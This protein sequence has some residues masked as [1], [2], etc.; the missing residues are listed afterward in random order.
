M[1]INVLV[2]AQVAIT[3]YVGVERCSTS[4]ASFSKEVLILAYARVGKISEVVGSICYIIIVSSIVNEEAVR[5]G[6]ESLLG[7]SLFSIIFAEHISVGETAIRVI[8]IKEEIGNASL[9]VRSFSEVQSFVSLYLNVSVGFF[10]GVSLV[11][12]ISKAGQGISDITVGSVVLFFVPYM[13][14]I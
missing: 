3:P 13:G 9:P 7:R 12:G 6:S 2:I 11:E 1:A 10:I 4:K 14:K 8:S 5:D